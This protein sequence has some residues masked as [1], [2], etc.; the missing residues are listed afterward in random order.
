[1]HVAT[2]GRGGGL[3][4]N[5]PK[6]QTMFASPKELTALPSAAKVSLMARMFSGVCA[7]PNVSLCQ[8]HGRLVAP[9]HSKRGS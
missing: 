3:P 9:P 2:R 6:L 5:C 1:M 4:M 7:P 8:V